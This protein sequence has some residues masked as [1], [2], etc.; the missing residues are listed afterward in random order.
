MFGSSS[1]VRGKTL[2]SR[3]Y[4]G[5]RCPRRFRLWQRCSAIGRFE[6]VLE[7]ELHNLGPHWKIASLGLH[8]HQPTAE[9]ALSFHIGFPFMTVFCEKFSRMPN[10]HPLSLENTDA[11]REDEPAAWEAEAELWTVAFLG[12][13]GA[14]GNNSTSNIMVLK[15]V[16]PSLWLSM[17]VQMS[18]Y[19]SRTWSLVSRFA[20]SEMEKTIS[21]L[22]ALKVSRT[23][24]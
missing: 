2:S 18:V 17:G 20:P 9:R 7:E 3:E 14:R 5:R 8:V 23:L 15:G 16:R 19:G 10:R 21:C 12:K 4:F 1:A 24:W 6:E 22:C 13:E 11:K